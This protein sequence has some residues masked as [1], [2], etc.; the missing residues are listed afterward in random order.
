MGASNA[1]VGTSSTEILAKNH[2][3]SMMIICNDSDETIY[4]AI[5]EDAVMNKGLRLIEN[6]YVAFFNGDPS[7][8]QA[9]NGI[10]ASG[11]KVV[12]TLEL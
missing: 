1:T 3:R 5:G 12:T 6:D 11:S 2:Q 10:C 9:V 4:L 7:L 8:S